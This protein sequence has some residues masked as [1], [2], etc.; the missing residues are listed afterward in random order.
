MKYSDKLK[1]PRWQ[2]KRLEIL[3]RDGWECTSCGSIDKTLHVHHTYYD[4]ALNPWDYHESTL[5]SLCEECHSEITEKTK[6]LDILLKS[7]RAAIGCDWGK[8]ELLTGFLLYLLHTSQNE[9]SA[10]VNEQLQ[11]FLRKT[12]LAQPETMTGFV[13]A[14]INTNYFGH[15]KQAY[16]ILLDCRQKNVHPTPCAAVESFTKWY[17]RG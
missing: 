2:K 5:V 10:Q 4:F 14:L 9:K 7:T 16:A 17:D 6:A 11:P 15:G 8:I 3:E 12:P 1:D 13:S